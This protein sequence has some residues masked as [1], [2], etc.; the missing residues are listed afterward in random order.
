MHY[1][2]SLALYLPLHHSIVRTMDEVRAYVKR[3]AQQFGC[4]SEEEW[5]KL[6]QYYVRPVMGGTCSLLYVCVCAYAQNVVA[7]CGACLQMLVFTARQQGGEYEY[8]LHYDPA[9]A[10][11]IPSD[12]AQ[13]TDIDLWKFWDHVKCDSL[14]LLRGCASIP[15]HGARIGLPEAWLNEKAH[16]VVVVAH[17]ADSDILPRAV[18]EEMVKRARFPMRIHEFGGVGH[19]PA[20]IADDQIQVVQHF[21]REGLAA[22]E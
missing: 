12:P 16:V 9:I 1:I 13:F 21:Y 10:S 20:L 19:A 3:I 8:E 2:P 6:T 4:R 11:S 7:H 15:L 22:E 18:A 17:R 5:E 14:L